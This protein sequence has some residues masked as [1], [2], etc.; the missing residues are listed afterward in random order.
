MSS[1]DPFAALRLRDFRL[2]SIGGLLA[3]IGQQMQ[4]VAVG[5]ELYERTGSAMALGWVGLVQALPVLLLALPAGQLADRFDRRRIVI[6]AQVFMSL[7]SAGLALLSYYKGSITLLYA[8]LL[9]WGIAKAFTWPAR[10]AMISQ[11]VPLNLFTNAATWNSTVFQTGAISG[12]ALGGLIIAYY[13]SALPV[14]I[15]DAIFGIARLISVLLIKSKQNSYS[16]EPMTLNSLVAGFDFVWK[17]KIIL[18]T[19]SLDLFAVLL[20][21]ATTLLPIFAKDILQVGPSG[22]GWLRAAPSIGAVLMAFI[23]VYLPPL[24]QAGKALLWSVI[25]FGLATIVF[26]FSKSFL[27][28]FSMLFIAGAVDNISVVVRQTLVQVLTP[29]E[30][31]GRVSAVNSIFITSSNEIGGF[32]SGLV[33]AFFSPIISVVSGGI[34]TILVVIATILIW[35]EVKQIGSLQEL[36]KQ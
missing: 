15:I 8:L 32:E 33:A 13:N 16:K 34:G 36:N 3:I 14:Y 10:A 35:P 29:D 12:P 23:L 5:W 31:R 28:S 11:L 21:G 17:T 4:S 27:L 18:A 9:M 20:G 26:G 24:K 30:M 2:Y 7:C 22:L 25:I 1:H 19:I 6:V